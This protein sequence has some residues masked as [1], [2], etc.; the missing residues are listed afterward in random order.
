MKKSEILFISS[1]L[2]PLIPA[3]MMGKAGYGWYYFLTLVTFY[4]CFG[5]YEFLSVKYRKA[6]ISQDLGKLH[7]DKPVIFWAIVATYGLMSVALIIHWI[8]M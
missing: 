8:S 1:L 5:L 7:K 6:S 3:F 4:A 2:I